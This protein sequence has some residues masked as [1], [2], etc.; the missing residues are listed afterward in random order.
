M[1]TG[2]HFEMMECSGTEESDGCTAL[3]YNQRHFKAENSMLYE[4]HARPQIRFCG[5]GEE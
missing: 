2:F 5:L 1:G 4:C 3:E